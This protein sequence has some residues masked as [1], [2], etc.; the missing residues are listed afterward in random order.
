MK[1]LSFALLGH[2]VA[3]SM[4]AV[5][6]R[7]A[8]TAAGLAHRYDLVDVPSESD[9]KRA[10]DA[11]RRGDLE[12]ANVTLPHKVSALGLADEVDESAATTGA[13]NV[14]ARTAGGRVVA[15]NTDVGA[16]ASRLPDGPRT[17]LVLGAGGAALAAVRA[18]VLRRTA[19]VLVTSRSFLRGAPEDPRARLL[20]AA[21]ADVLPW[22]GVDGDVA[23]TLDVVV[24]ATSAGVR[25]KD[26]QTA[27]LIQLV[28]WDAMHDGAFAI[29]LVYG[30]A[31][32]PFVL[33]AIERGL[34]AED[35]LAM[36]S[37]QAEASFQI[38]LGARC[39]A[40]VMRSAAEAALADLSG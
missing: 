31:K 15:H 7:A 1:S 23:A 29:D 19:R 30:S 27:A 26:A 5:M 40:H 24:Q 10:V 8:F 14:L 28:P 16:L 18:L 21:G 25:G 38:W 12:G 11:V 33:R 35:G 39:P 3:H 9:L 34:R 32:T 4:S 2:P 37:A 36:L 20:R 22:E 6:F 13:A 17:A